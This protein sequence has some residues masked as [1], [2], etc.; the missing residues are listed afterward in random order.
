VYLKATRGPKRSG[1]V[2]VIARAIGERKERRNE[3]KQPKKTT[4]KK[5]RRN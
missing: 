1:R 5:K 3:E 2:V 4:K